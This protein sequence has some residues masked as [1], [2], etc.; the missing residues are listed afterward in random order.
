MNYKAFRYGLFTVAIVAVGE[1]ATI[2]IYSIYFQIGRGLSAINSA[3]NLAPFAH[4][5][6]HLFTDRWPALQQVWR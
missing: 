2:F 4:R 6:V 1:F 3:L 5:N